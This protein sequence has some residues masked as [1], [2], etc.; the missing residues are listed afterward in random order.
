MLCS[1]NGIKMAYFY[2]NLLCDGE[3][4]CCRVPRQT[5]YFSLKLFII[6]FRTLGMRAV[7]NSRRT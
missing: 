2:K 7:R 3:H 1:Q 6:M 5:A 4:S